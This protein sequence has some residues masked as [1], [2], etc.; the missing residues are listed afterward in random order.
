MSGKSL[1]SSRGFWVYAMG[2]VAASCLMV[3]LSLLVFFRTWLYRGD[4]VFDT[5]GFWP[6]INYSLELPNFDLEQSHNEAW[7]LAG[8][9]S[10]GRTL[11]WV[12]LESLQ[13]RVPMPTLDLRVS[14]P[15]GRLA[16]D[17]S[18]NLV[19]DHRRSMEGQKSKGDLFPDCHTGS[20][21]E[22]QR[23]TSEVLAHEPNTITCSMFFDSRGSAYTIRLDCL[24]Q[25][26][27][28]V[29]QLRLASGWK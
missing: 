21:R 25:C 5:E 12:D 15:S 26:E 11:L 27:G 16:L 28:V 2:F 10:H 9:S 7:Q 3:W 4:G 8:Y 17:Y 18:G 6:L 20:G 24:E 14:S 13:G 29:G 1:L 22:A 23:L 19:A